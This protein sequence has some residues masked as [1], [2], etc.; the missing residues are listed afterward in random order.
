MNDNL[1]KIKIMFT[2]YTF[3][4]ID[5]SSWKEEIWDIDLDDYVCCSGHM[6]GCNGETNRENFNR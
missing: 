5:F 4:P 1:L 6:C 2:R 3:F